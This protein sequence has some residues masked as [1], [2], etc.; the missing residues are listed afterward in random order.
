MLTVNVVYLKMK[1]ISMRNNGT[2]S[3]ICS[4]LVIDNDVNI[5]SHFVVWMST[6]DSA[7]NHMVSSRSIWN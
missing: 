1:L 5:E 3:N 4:K 7:G 2:N 6:V